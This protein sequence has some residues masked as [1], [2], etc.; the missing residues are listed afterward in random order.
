MAP[1]MNDS[2]TKQES[3]YRAH[4]LTPL[5]LMLSS[6]KIGLNGFIDNYLLAR[7]VPPIDADSGREKGE[8]ESFVLSMKSAKFPRDFC[9]IQLYARFHTYYERIVEQKIKQK[10]GKTKKQNEEMKDGI[11]K[12]MEQEKSFILQRETKPNEVEEWAAKE[13]SIWILKDMKDFSM[14]LL[15]SES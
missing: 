14:T 15:L 6:K 13:G 12:M 8:F 7:D 3:F 5:E 4:W 2:L 9:N 11:L 1:F 10:C